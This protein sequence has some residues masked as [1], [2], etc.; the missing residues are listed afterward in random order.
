MKIAVVAGGWH[1]P[2]HFY[3]EMAAQSVRA[4][5]FVVAHRNPELPIVR[6]EKVTD[7]RFAPSRLGE[8]DRE[9][10]AV[11]VTLEALE[12]AGWQYE[13]APNVCG[14]QCFLNQWLERHDYWRYDAILS[15]HDDT[16]IRRRDLFEQLAGDWVILA[17]GTNSVEPAGYFRGSF[18]FWRKELILALGASI[19][20][21]EV[22]LTREGKTDSP[23][24]RETLQVWNDTGV[25]VRTWLR[26]HGFAGRVRS[27]SPYYRVSPWAIEGE[28]GFLQ[29]QAGGDWSLARGLVAYPLP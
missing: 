13:E 11:P 8:L 18:E 1:W 4:D 10:Y 25:P 5:L 29:R 28:R 3:R 26:E 20:L 2:W 21:G 17:N 6:E 9:M 12:R 19:D 22:R 23:A 16:Y 27:L 14:D 24:D 15:C 7:L